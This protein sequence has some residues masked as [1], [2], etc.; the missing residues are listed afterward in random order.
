MSIDLSATGWD[1]SE[2]DLVNGPL[3][4]TK[5]TMS[6]LLA[7]E[8]ES[9]VS[10]SAY[11]HGQRFQS[12]TA[13]A[14]EFDL[15][16]ATAVPYGELAWLALDA[17]WKRIMRPDKTVL[18]SVSDMAGTV[19]TLTARMVSEDT[20]LDVD[21]SGR[22]R[23]VLTYGLVADDPWWYGDP[24]VETFEATAEPV[25]FYGPTGLGPPF[26]LGSSSTPGRASVSNRGDVDEWPVWTFYGPTPRFS[27]RVGGQLIAGEFAIPDSD[28]VTVD[29]RPFRKSALLSDGTNVT[30]ALASRQFA[31]VPAGE[32]VPVE[33][34]TYGP[35][36]STLTLTPKFFRG[37]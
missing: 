37:Y 16:V 14:R 10:Q 17:A 1:G 19:R 12:W 28:Y 35:S 34:L 13:K 33:V 4:A 21:P 26:H 25:S 7:F 30:R 2:W 9:F 3:R 22:R 6:M 5:Q 31:R 32:N 8:S 23:T 29:T 20:P 27:A 15:Q 36:M 11:V 18:F 24:I